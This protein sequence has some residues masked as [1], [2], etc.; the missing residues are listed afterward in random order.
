MAGASSILEGQPGTRSYTSWALARDL[1]LVPPLLRYFQSSSS[2][3]LDG[4]PKTEE[5]AAFAAEQDY[6]SDPLTC[7]RL[8][9]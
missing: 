9:C 4:R 3:P 8:F 1:V 2:S 5:R 7:Q 6:P